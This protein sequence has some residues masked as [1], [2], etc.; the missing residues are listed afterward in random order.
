MLF[1][2]QYIVSRDRD[3]NIAHFQKTSN[4]N[5]DK[6]TEENP[7]NIAH[8]QKT[9]NHNLS[10]MLPMIFRIDISYSYVKIGTT[11]SKQLITEI[12][13]KVYHLEPDS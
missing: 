8:F 10:W 12:S 4:H 2:M 3:C 1:P 5:V 13:C 9:S 11:K 6:L 7:I